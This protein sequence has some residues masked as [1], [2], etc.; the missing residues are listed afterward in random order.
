MRYYKR[1]DKTFSRIPLKQHILRKKVR[2][3]KVPEGL[4]FNQLPRLIK[5]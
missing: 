3:K 4:L 2:R 1:I 5:I